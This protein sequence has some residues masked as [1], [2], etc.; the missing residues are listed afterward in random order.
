MKPWW[1]FLPAV[2]LMLGYPLDSGKRTGIRRLEGYRLAQT[3]QVK[4]PKIVPGGQWPESR[5]A[6]RLLAHKT[7]DVT[8]Q[9]PKD[10]ALQRGLEAIFAGRNES[11]GLAVLDITDPDHPRYAAVREEVRQLPGSVGK[12]CIAAGAM[13]A[14]A[15]RA[16]QPADRERLLRETVR[17]ADRFVLVDGKTV[18]FFEEGWPAVVNRQI[19]PGDRFSLWEWLDHMLSQSSNAAGSF[20]WKEMMLLRRF[21]TQYPPSAEEEKAYLGGNKAQLSKDAME[22]LEEPLRAANIDTASFRLGSLFTSGGNAVVPGISSYGT[23]REMLRFLLRVE[24]GR[25]VDEWSSLE[26]KRLI[27]FARPRYR[28]GSSPALNGAGVFFK[29]GSFFQ[30]VPEAGFT[31]KAYAGNKTNIMNSVAIVEGQ[32]KT[33]LVSLMSNVLR[34]NAAVEHQRVATLVDQLIRANK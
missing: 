6:L 33:Y 15:K 11:Y 8:A 5:I 28:Y 19:R 31:C 23:A 10:P 1:I 16:P 34:T 30:C 22:T 24:Q 29:S 3:G 13:N 12:L 27:Y 21:G 17:A 7:L 25:M 14:L 20:T 18:P 4:G 9:S 2:S 32:D 26:I